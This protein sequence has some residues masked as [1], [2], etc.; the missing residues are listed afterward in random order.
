[1]SRNLNPAIS[2]NGLFRGQT[3]SL[4]PTA[5]MNG[6]LMDG[7]EAQFT[8]IVDPFWN[9]NV[10]LGI[11]PEHDHQDAED[12]AHGVTYATHVE[13]AYLDSRALPA[14][15]GL[16]AGR[17]LV[18]FGKH[19]PLHLHQYSFAD[20]PLGV[21]SFLG[22]HGLSENGAQLARAL[23]LP[24]FSDLAAYMVSG[25][26]EVFD[27]EDEDLAWGGRLVNLW[28]LGDDTT[29]ELSASFLHGSD[30]RYPDLGKGVDFRGIDMTWKWVSS[31]RTGGPAAKVT[32]EVISP[33]YEDG[34][35]DPLG[36]YALAQCRIQR[37][38]WLGLGLGRARALPDED[39]ADDPAHDHGFEGDIREY[40]GNLT[41]APSEFSFVR[42]EVGY[43]DDRITGE[44]DWRA[45][46]QVNF[47]IGSHPAHVY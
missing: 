14:G 39:G 25:D 38:W 31:Q 29:L 16:R 47:T 19:L 1:V 10:T 24:W 36:W 45:I 32:G 23:P 28:D 8:A 33:R 40:K 44:H 7:V 43:Y 37:H 30:G 15:L 26:G 46:V 35:A 13:E 6:F 17:F 2:V 27:A 12:S 3:S 21:S 5:D 42:G 11:H 18:P 34:P 9:A 4:E 20:A 22:E 41:Y